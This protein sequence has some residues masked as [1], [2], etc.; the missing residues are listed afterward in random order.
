M[1]APLPLHL[2]L[3]L[4]RP[5]SPRPPQSWRPIGRKKRE[6]VLRERSDAKRRN[7]RGNG[8]Q[9]LPAQLPVGWLFLPYQAILHRLLQLY[10]LARLPCL[11]SL[12]LPT[13]ALCWWT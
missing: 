4:P 10:C 6:S 3:F 12:P 5:L 7:A 11:C 8:R 1:R 2:L 13:Q 9:P